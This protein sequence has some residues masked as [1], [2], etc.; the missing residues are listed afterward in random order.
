[1]SESDPS[2][3][4]VNDDSVDDK[5]HVGCIKL[6][7]KKHHKY[8]EY[9]G[10]LMYLMVCTRPDIAFTVNFLAR[11]C[12]SPEKRHMQSVMKLVR[13]LKGTKTKGLFYPAREVD[14]P[15]IVDLVGYVDAAHGDCLVTRKSTSGYLF[16]I[17]G[18]PVTWKSSRQSVITTSST[19][20]EYVSACDGTKEAVWLRHLLEDMGCTAT[21]PTVLHEDNNSCIAQTENP[22]HH[23]RTKHIDIAYH[24]TRQMVD[25]DVVVL[26]KI[27]TADQ[28]ADMLTKPL[29][30][31]LFSKHFKMLKMRDT[32]VS[33]QM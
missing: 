30:N 3:T 28:V 21:E 11:A 27:D 17:N 10:K 2:F 19:E 16:C 13:Y 15:V 14:K 20:A 7:A 33:L 5:K 1:M 29:G 4:V 18:T 26:V 9:I 31:I 6:D 32:K 12:A 24:F 25:E 22:L 23:K 8:R